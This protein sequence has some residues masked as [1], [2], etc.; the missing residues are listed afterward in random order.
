[1]LR[2]PALPV[3][4]RP[5]KS[6]SPK[7]K[8]KKANVT[9]TTPKPKAPVRQPVHQQKKRSPEASKIK[10]KKTKALIKNAKPQQSK[11]VT[12]YVTALRSDNTV[13]IRI[14]GDRFRGVPTMD[15]YDPRSVGDKV[16][17]IKHGS[18]Y[19][20]M[21]KLSSDDLD[22][23]PTIFPVDYAQ[24]TWGVDRGAGDKRLWIESEGNGFRVGRRSELF[25]VNDWDYFARLGI[26][27]YN[28]S[29]NL[30]T[31]PAD[32]TKQIDVYVERDDWDDGYEG[33]A[34]FTLFGVKNDSMPS[35]PQSLQYQTTLNPGSIDFTLEPGEMKIITLPDTWRNNI[36]GTVG[37]DTIRGFVIEPAGSSNQPTDVNSHTFGIFTTL[38]GGLRIFSPS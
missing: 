34:T 9:V 7:P 15:T 36:G 4:R 29:S 3:P 13:N 24:W 8:P 2:S 35:S 25:P 20:V 37:A 30:M 32:T 33:A 19:I 22:V 18:Q 5:V 38:T 23:S 27:F 17:V 14:N 6:V 12:G 28:G 10:V 31:G 11:A 21:G 16:Q 26:G 1:M